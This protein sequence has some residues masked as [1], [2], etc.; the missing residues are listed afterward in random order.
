MKRFVVVFGL[1]FSTSA[2]AGTI[3]IAPF[4][5]GNDVTIPRLE[6]QR[7]TLQTVINGSIEGGGQ[8]IRQ[9]SITSYDLSTAINP[10]TFRDEAFNDWTYS[11]M[12]APTSGSLSSTTTAGVSYVNGVRVE[13]SATAHTY[14][15]SKDTYVYINAGGFFE[16]QE[17]ANGAS[18][19]TT[20][21]NDLLL[22]KAVTNGTTVSSVTDSRTMS[23]QIT[24]N[25][26]NFAAD[27]RDQAVV[28]RD[29]TTAMHLEPG[30]FA[31]GS[32][33]YTNLVDTSSRS[34][35]TGSNWIEG[36][37]PTQANLKYYVY[38]YN[39]SG[40][41]Y[42]FKFSSADP[43]YA[44]TSSSTG[45]TLQYYTSGGTTYRALG[46]I[47][48]DSSG[49]IQTYNYSQYPSP[50]TKNYAYFSTGAVA[51]G[52]A[53]TPADDTIP[54]NNATEGVSFLSI[55]FKPS[56]IGATITVRATVNFASNGSTQAVV[57]LCQDGTANALAVSA[58]RGDTV[59]KM[60]NASLVYSTI[61]TSTNL[62]TYRIRI[63]D[64]AG[65]TITF[66]G[67]G[68]SRLFGGNLSSA[69][70]VEESLS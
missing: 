35:A 52:A 44:D 36:S 68:G 33:L 56:T 24:A 22:F 23:I 39:S 48:N 53:T 60:Y 26:S 3:S 67:T 15:A 30:Q 54:Q 16:Y 7:S 61:A 5:S 46:W 70:S 63:G 18:A 29:S 58:Q 64:T 55:P 8:N 69:I 40:T 28:A 4:I 1:L 49:L 47:S 32:T 21:V 31:I 14:T 11:G 13:T 38:G 25:S 57:Y 2:F 37:T 41:A 34:T 50:T 65:G 19:P 66:N 45:G 59:D 27:Y 10:V 20:P 62:I 17:V 43:V 6:T 51:T 42:D 12:L 9:G